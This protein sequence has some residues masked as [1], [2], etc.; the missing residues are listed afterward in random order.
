MIESGLGLGEDSFVQVT[1]VSLL[2]PAEPDVAFDL[3]FMLR[4]LLGKSF[5]DQPNDHRMS[6]KFIAE[7][8]AWWRG[9]WEHAMRPIEDALK[10]CLGRSCLIYEELLILWAEVE[11]NVCCRTL[12]HRGCVGTD[13]IAILN[14]LA[15][16]GT[17]SKD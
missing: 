11:V 14:Q 12:T 15:C 9:F 6:W 2:S 17:A 8:A 4:I 16:C 7:R 1:P 13:A 10:R 5:K 3:L